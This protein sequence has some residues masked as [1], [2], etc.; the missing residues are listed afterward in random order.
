MHWLNLMLTIVALAIVLLSVRQLGDGAASC[1]MEVA[2]PADAT[3]ATD[4]VD[5]TD[6][7][8]EDEAPAQGN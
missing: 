2:G 1:V 5:V 6:T 3:D 4:L 8:Q 7:P